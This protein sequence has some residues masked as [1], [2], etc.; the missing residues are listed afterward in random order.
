MSSE[1]PSIEPNPVKNDT[2]LVQEEK[3]SHKNEEEQNEDNVSVQ[4]EMNT[5]A[6]SSIMRTALTEGFSSL[7]AFEKKNGIGGMMS[8]NIHSFVLPNPNPD[9]CRAKVNFVD[10]VGDHNI[11]TNLAAASKNK[12]DNGANAP[13]NMNNNNNA[14]N[15]FG[16]GSVLGSSSSL[17]SPSYFDLIDN[18]L[19]RDHNHTLRNIPYQNIRGGAVSNIETIQISCVKT[20]SAPIVASMSS[21]GTG[22]NTSV[23][24]VV[25]RSESASSYGSSTNTPAA[26]PA[27]SAISLLFG[28]GRSSTSTPSVPTIDTSVGI[29]SN[30]SGSNLDSNHGTSDENASNSASQPPSTKSSMSDSTAPTSNLSTTLSNATRAISDP[31]NGSTTTSALKNPAS[32]NS[33]QKQKQK[34]PVTVNDATSWHVGQYCHVYVA[35]CENPEHYKTKVRPSLQAFISQIDSNN[36]APPNAKS[37]NSSSSVSSQSHNSNNLS[38]YNHGSHKAKNQNSLANSSGHPSKLNR[39]SS[40]I[41]AQGSTSFTSSQYLIVYVPIQKHSNYGSNQNSQ[42]PFGKRVRAAASLAGRSVVQRSSDS[43]VSSMDDSTIIS[44]QSS[45]LGG[46]SV[47]GNNGGSVLDNNNGNVPADL[48]SLSSKEKEVFKRLNYDFPQGR[49]CVLSTLLLADGAGGVG[50]GYSIMTPAQTAIHQ[51]EWNIFMKQ[52]GNVIV[53]GFRDR[54]RMYDEQLRHLDKRRAM[55]TA[56]ASTRLNSFKKKM[57]LTHYFLVKESLAFSYEQMQLHSEALLQYKEFSAVIPSALWDGENGKDN[58]N[59]TTI[60][61]PSELSQAA[62]GD[63]TPFRSKIRENDVTEIEL[64]HYLF[65][66]EIHLLF[67]LRRPVDVISRAHQHITLLDNL[68]RQQELQYKK[69]NSIDLL[70]DADA[71]ADYS[72]ARIEASILSNCWDVKCACDSYFSFLTKNKTNHLEKTKGT[73]SGSKVSG[74]GATNSVRSSMRSMVSGIARGTIVAEKERDASKKL[75][76]LLEF[77]RLRMLVLGDM[78]FEK[79]PIRLAGLDRPLD[80]HKEWLPLDKLSNWQGIPDSSESNHSEDDIV[81]CPRKIETSQ[82][83]GIINCD[84]LCDCF[85]SKTSYENK[86]LELLDTI[87]TLYQH[88]GFA[89]FATRLLTERAEIFILRNDFSSAARILA[90]IIDSTSVRDQLWDKAYLWRLFRLACCQRMSAASPISYLKTLVRCFTSRL[91]KITPLKTAILFQR[92]LE[93]LIKEDS[94]SECSLSISPLFEIEFIISPSN[95]TKGSIYSQHP[96]GFLRKK[97]TKYTCMVGDTM[98][99]TLTITSSLPKSVTLNRLRLFLVSYKNYEK[100]FQRSNAGRTK[101]HGV[102]ILESDAYRIL[103]LDGDIIINHGR[104]EF[105]FEWIPMSVG[106][107]ALASM[108]LQWSNAAFFHDSS[109]FRRSIQG[110]EVLPSM[111]T[112]TIELSPLFLIPGHEQEI[113]LVFSSGKDIITK[114]HA[115]FTCSDGLTIFD[116]GMDVNDEKA[117]RKSCVVDI[118]PCEPGS[119]CLIKTL[120]RSSS[121][122]Q[123]AI[124]GGKMGGVQTI[125]ANV[126]TYYHHELYNKLTAS[127]DEEPKSKPMVTELDMMVTTLDRPALTVYDSSATTIGSTRVIVSAFLQCNTPLPFFIKEWDVTIPPPLILEKNGDLNK[128]LFEHPVAVGEELFFSFSCERIETTKEKSMDASLENEKPTLHVVLQDEIGKTFHQ[129]LPLDLDEFYEKL[130]RENEYSGMNIVQARLNCSSDEGVVGAPAKFIMDVDI[131]NLEVLEKR[132]SKELENVSNLL[133]ENLLIYTISCDENDWILSGR[134]QGI[135]ERSNDENG[136]TSFS[137]EFVGIPTRPGLLATFPKINLKYKQQLGKRY[138]ED[139]TEPPITVHCIYPDHFRSL[140]YTN[141]MALATTTDIRPSRNKT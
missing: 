34:S 46:T 45:Y 140:S 65:C 124:Y 20:P 2:T 104:N 10:P 55:A 120:V 127:G 70:D 66:R 74:T 15:R 32:T 95:G 107:F 96:L 77:A 53:A 29:N 103:P 69:K 26:P 57:N 47:S 80:T 121:L 38:N 106:H 36:K 9:I 1:D 11:M 73:S 116:P 79:N 28:R 87:T 21:T 81:V 18:I 109:T 8:G 44:T 48:S 115:D 137:L 134:V 5:A 111:S 17:N 39:S 51:Q 94:V 89:R 59:S 90:K 123:K 12:D 54:F 72:M 49:V 31:T 13:S 27:P 136:N 130:K 86:Y 99:I 112:Q 6:S 108:D 63:T 43:N 83:P 64:Y 56:N 139:T 132:S 35:A 135:V 78:T 122:P 117:W 14:N 40:S 84:W 98:T 30:P 82:I 22:G 25:K 75:S 97:L 105:K 101:S 42:Q 71:T 131:S 16:R 76:S 128:G 85:T 100:A 50:G 33:K 41:Y 102:H 7:A 58:V 141:H 68:K 113:R 60:I 4:S 114:G 23:G 61:N 91:S 93:A 37:S 88:A 119:T 118:E 125:K 19:R 126:Q 24:T 129:V 67:K 52:L 62:I 133:N 92:D 138:I 3:G 110:I